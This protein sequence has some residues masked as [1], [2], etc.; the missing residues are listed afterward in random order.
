MI[1]SFRFLI[2]LGI[3]SIV[4]SDFYAFISVSQTGEGFEGIIKFRIKSSME[5]VNMGIMPAFTEYHI[6]EGDII[7]QMFGT[8]NVKLA[9]I[10]IKGN[11]NS[12]YMIDDE[13]RTAVKVRI[14]NADEESPIGNVPDEFREEYEKAIKETE[15]NLDSEKIN[16]IETNETLD[17]Q[18]YN[19]TK[20]L[21]T[22][23][24]GE[25]FVESAVWLTDKI[26]VEVPE[27]LKDKNNPLLL[28]MNEKGFPLRF[29]GKSNT[30]GQ[31]YDFEMVAEKVIAGN[32][33]PGDF[34]IP[35]NY[36]IS[37]MTSFLE[38]K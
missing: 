26:Y 1:Y 21:V 18:G 36:H 24:A 7:I 27:V 8:D 31:S 15:S 16:L 11:Q 5:D 2:L 32:L 34:E 13:A 28:F 4:H 37:D 29:L 38:R 10:L 19:C 20:Y 17:I 30:Q 35:E 22:A 12:F 3:L 23:E 33:D 9:R 25:A 14:N 6:K